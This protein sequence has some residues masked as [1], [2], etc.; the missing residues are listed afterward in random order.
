MHVRGEDISESGPQQG[1]GSPYRLEWAVEP[2][3][4]RPGV[5]LALVPVVGA[6]L[7]SGICGILGLAYAV[8]LP[9][10]GTIVHA[11]DYT[12]RYTSVNPSLTE[13][14]L[15]LSISIASG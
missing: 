5:R 11:Y 8:S 13:T 6:S 10:T 15:Y 1:R 12:G 4:Q 3:R 14:L 9:R 7:W 2:M